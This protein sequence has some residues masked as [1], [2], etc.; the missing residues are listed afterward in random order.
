[1]D[2]GLAG[3]SVIVTGGARGIGAATA[4]AFAAEG[5]RVAIVDRDAEA[6]RALVDAIDSDDVAFLE[7]DLSDPRRCR[8]VVERVET[9]H[10]GVH[11]LVNNAGFNDGVGLDRDP[12]EF[13]ESVRSNLLHVFSMTH[14]ARASLARSRGAVVNL[15]SK[16]A[17][18]GQG[19]TSGYAAAKGAIHAL[20][21][22][23]ALALASDGVRVNAVVPA[24]CW[25]D[26]YERWIASLD[27]PAATKRAIERLVPLEGRM[28]T[29]EEVASAVVFLASP[30][31]SHTTGQLVFVDG[32]YTHLD[33]ACSHDHA[34]WG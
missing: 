13:L 7:A 9:H 20:T 4:R 23:W 18:T 31:S 17:L 19:S 15:G 29:A 32:G 22:E 11:V 26:Q 6:G 28:T 16:V 34:K 27:D 3:R 5:A 33:R 2:L 24:E 1:M 25:S 10:G 8:S 14:Y 21:R 12:E 30:R